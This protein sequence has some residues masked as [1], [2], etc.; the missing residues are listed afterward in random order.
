M[1][2]FVYINIHIHICMGELSINNKQCI[3]QQAMFDFRTS[4]GYATT[5][6]D[7]WC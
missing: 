2:I 3:F 7:I 1:Y 5:T 4:G 6:R